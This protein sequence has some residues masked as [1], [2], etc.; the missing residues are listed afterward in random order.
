MPTATK[1]SKNTLKP[2]SR[3]DL[4]QASKGVVAVGPSGAV[5]RIRAIN[6]ERHAL[7]GGLPQSLRRLATQGAR[8]VDKLL[9]ANEDKVDKAGLKTR[10][11]LDKL[12]LATIMEPKLQQEDLGTG[13]LDDS[14]LLH[15]ADYKWALNIAFGNEDEDGE[16]K[17]L[18]GRMPINRLAIWRE[19]HDCPEECAACV[20]VVTRFTTAGA[21]GD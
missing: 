17:L 15:P 12:V 7:A 4:L 21:T 1:P 13:E 2:S 14:P 20:Q 11:Y 16:G 10:D 9:S 3:E 18:W 8:G 6:V 5:F 19:E